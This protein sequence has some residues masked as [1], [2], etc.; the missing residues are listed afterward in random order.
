MEWREPE[1]SQMILWSPP[2]LPTHLVG[3]VTVPD[4]QL[5]VLRGR[6]QVPA[7]TRPVHGVDFGQMT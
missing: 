1:H 4:Y 5:P 3:G 7:V 6:D 2:L